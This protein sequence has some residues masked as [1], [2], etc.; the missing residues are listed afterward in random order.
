MSVL[1]KDQF[2]LVSIHQ[3]G[4]VVLTISDHLEWDDDEEHI[5]ALVSKINNYLDGI[6]SGQFVAQYP[7]AEGKEIV[8]QIIAQFQPNNKGYEFLQEASKT[9]QS[10]GYRLNIG[11]IQNGEIV[12]EEID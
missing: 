3:D 2:D 6:E 8:I 4:Y 10:A 11:F 5:L 9:L 7:G 1:D 12:I